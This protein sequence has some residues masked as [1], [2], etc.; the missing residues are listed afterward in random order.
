MNKYKPWGWTYPSKY[1]YSYTKEIYI[2]LRYIE[3][4]CRVV[5]VYDDKVEAETT[6]E[7]LNKERAKIECYFG[8]A[9]VKISY[10][11]IKKTIK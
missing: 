2:L 8:K 5:A 3:E 7:I 4:Q 9:A 10:A 6:K 11:V 1:R